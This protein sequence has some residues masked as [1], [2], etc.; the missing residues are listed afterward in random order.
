MQR[1]H[2][3]TLHVQEHRAHTHTALCTQ[4]SVQ[5]LTCT[6]THAHRWKAPPAPWLCCPQNTGPGPVSEHSSPSHQPDP[7]AAAYG[8][9]VKITRFLAHPF[10]LPQASRGIGLGQSWRTGSPGWVLGHPG[11]LG[12]CEHP[13]M[14]LTNKLNVLLSLGVPG[15][16][17][18]SGQHGGGGW[19]LRTDGLGTPIEHVLAAKRMRARGRLAGR[20]HHGGKQHQGQF[21]KR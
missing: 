19:Q 12:V 14:L 15:V 20:S 7:P 11:V 6:H 5:V 9:S 16:L 8:F 17:G 18:G 4:T 10:A 13:Q 3:C 2:A 1:K 21:G